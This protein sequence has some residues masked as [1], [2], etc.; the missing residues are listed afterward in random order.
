MRACDSSTNRNYNMWQEH[1]NLALWAAVVAGQDC[2]VCAPMG[3][4]ESLCFEALI[5]VG[6][7][8]AGSQKCIVLV[9]IL[10][11]PLLLLMKAQQFRIGPSDL[12]NI[13]IG[14][15]AGLRLMSL[16]NCKV[17]MFHCLFVLM[18][19]NWGCPSTNV[20]WTLIGCQDVQSHLVTIRRDTV[21]ISQWLVES[22]N[23]DAKHWGLSVM[24][25][26]HTC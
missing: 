7:T 20:A 10:L 22:D 12:T 14:V 18:T 3:G 24:L 19:P 23:E 13:L 15:F 21:E 8:V 26:V 6:D 9:L 4:G 1:Q 25:S 2:V 11:S 5:S 17:I 16:S